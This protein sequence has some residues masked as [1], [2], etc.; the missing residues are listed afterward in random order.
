MWNNSNVKV[1]N[2]RIADFE[3]QDPNYISNTIKINKVMLGI[4]DDFNLLSVSVAGTPNGK[5]LVT[6]VIEVFDED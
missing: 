1:I 4:P 5:Y 3:D 6:L 2:Y